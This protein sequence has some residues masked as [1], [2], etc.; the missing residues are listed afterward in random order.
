MVLQLEEL[1][2][3]VGK[4]I[5]N[6]KGIILGKLEGVKVHQRRNIPEFLIMRC[7]RF[8]GKGNRYFAI[9]AH[10]PWVTVGRHGKLTIRIERAVLRIVLEQPAK[11]YD[12]L[13]RSVTSTVVELNGYE[14]SNS[15]I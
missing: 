13:K 9:P 12:R 3:S 10:P 6:H 2:K 4:Y 14:K 1:T 5:K 15:P 8:P 11:E 7:N